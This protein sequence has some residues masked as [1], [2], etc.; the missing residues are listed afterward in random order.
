MNPFTAIAQV[1]EL[2]VNLLSKSV[3][4]T[5][6]VINSVDNYVH[7]VEIHSDSILTAYEL[8]SGAE[9]RDLKIKLDQ[10]LGKSKDK[11]KDKAK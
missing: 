10:S 4:T 8:T 1:L 5:N 7:V 6:R 9:L 3:G 2:L 11:S